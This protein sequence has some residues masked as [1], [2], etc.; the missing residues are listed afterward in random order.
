M[1]EVKIKLL[2]EIKASNKFFV[3]FVF[4]TEKDYKKQLLTNMI[5]SLNKGNYRTAKKVKV[6]LKEKEYFF[7]RDQKLKKPLIIINGQNIEEIPLEEN[8]EFWFGTE[9]SD[10]ENIKI[11]F[12]EKSSFEIIVGVKYYY[13]DSEVRKKDPHIKEK[14]LNEIFDSIRRSFIFQKPEEGPFRSITKTEDYFWEEFLTEFK[15]VYNKNQNLNQFFN[16]LL[17]LFELKHSRRRPQQ[18]EE[19]EYSY[20][21]KP[22]EIVIDKE[23]LFQFF[24]EFLKQNKI[25]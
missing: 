12:K 21:K 13:L 1:R 5:N 20:L 23:K 25:I 11:V 15:K 10:S 6:F 8:T 18:E 7:K 19:E 2:E 17:L 22:K 3:S 4:E 16:K 24:L 14:F 9:Q